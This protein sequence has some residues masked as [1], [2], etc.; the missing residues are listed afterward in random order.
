MD[1]IRRGVLAFAIKS[2]IPAGASIQSATLTL[3]LSRSGSG[4]PTQAITVHRLLADWGE[5]GS[6]SGSSGVGAAAQAGDATWTHS[7]FDTG[8]W[9]SPG[10]DFTSASAVASVGGEGSYGW[11]SGQMVADV[12]NWLDAPGGNFGWLLRGVESE[13]SARRFDSRE[14]GDPAVRPLLEVIYLPR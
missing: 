10:G 1:K 7:F 13:K 12:Q 9:S 14:N 2:N 5:A 4:K 6:N 3:N 11:S 8:T